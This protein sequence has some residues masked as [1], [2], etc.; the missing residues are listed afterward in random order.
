MSSDEI[1]THDRSVDVSD[2][3]WGSI[4]YNYGEVEIRW[5]GGVEM[6]DRRGNAG[7]RVRL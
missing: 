5:G 1:F 7:V 6:G 4:L 3:V 2:E